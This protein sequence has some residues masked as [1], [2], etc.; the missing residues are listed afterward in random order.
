MC[1]E[2]DICKCPIKYFQHTLR[3][4]KTVTI[5]VS[6]SYIYFNHYSELKTLGKTCDFA[7]ENTN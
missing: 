7:N 5:I 4:E 6:T 3:G 1:H 2:I